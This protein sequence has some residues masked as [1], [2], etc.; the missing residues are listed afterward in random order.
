MSSVADS[1]DQALPAVRQIALTQPFAWLRR[2]WHDMHAC[3][4][5]ACCTVWS[6]PSAAWPY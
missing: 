2:G 4:A 3:S 6:L 5:P 1:P